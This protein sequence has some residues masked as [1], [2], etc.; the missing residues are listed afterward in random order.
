MTWSGTW[1]YTVLCF[2][3]IRSAHTIMLLYAGILFEEGR[4]IKRHALM[5]EPMRIF[6][7]I[8]GLL[9]KIV[10]MLILS[11]KGG[12]RPWR[13]GVEVPTPLPYVEKTLTCY[14]LVLMTV[15]V[16]RC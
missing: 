11:L 16:R 1:D 3:C 12:R 10:S 9:W 7:S 14:L 2:I 6:L 5:N 4:L 13:G 8:M 15:L